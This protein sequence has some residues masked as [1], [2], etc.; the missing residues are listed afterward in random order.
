MKETIDVNTGEVKVNSNGGILRSIAIGSCLGVAAYDARG[1]IGA[2]AHV[3]LP[4]RAPKSKQGE[5]SKYAADGIDELI[6]LMTEAGSC[7]D[8]IEVSIV[9]GGNVLMRPDDSICRDN[10]DSTIKILEKNNIPIRAKCVGGTTRRSV[11]MD[12]EAGSVFYTEGDGQEKLL[13]Q[14]GEPDDQ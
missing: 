13:W 1:R 8:D 3:M 11:F 9:G 10:I 7:R 12:I 5:K 2:L 6:N 14:A 4:G